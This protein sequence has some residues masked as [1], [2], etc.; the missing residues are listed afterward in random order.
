MTQDL[1]RIELSRV[2]NARDT[3]THVITLADAVK[4][5]TGSNN[6]ATV[7]EIRRL[8]VGGERE[9][10]DGIKRAL[11]AFMFAGTFTR[12]KND[13]IKQHSGLLV[14]DF[15]NIDTGLKSRLARDPHAVL[16]FVSPSGNGLKLVVRI[17]NDPTGHGESFEMARRYFSE[18]FSVEADAGKDLAR[19]CFVSHDPDAVFRDTAKVLHRPHMTIQTTHDYTDHISNVRQPPPGEHDTEGL[20]GLC[21]TNDV[22]NSTLPT[23]PGQRHR[24]L[25]SLARGLRFD[26]G[27]AEAPPKELKAIIR[28]WYEM[29]KPCIGTQ[30]F[31][32]SWSDFVHAWSRV[33]SPLSS[34]NPVAAAWAAVQGGEHPKEAEEYD[35]EEVRQLVALCWHLGRNAETFYLAMRTAAGMLNVEAMTVC[36]WFKMLQADDIIA[37]VKTGNTHT[38]STYRW[39]GRGTDAE[40]HA[41]NP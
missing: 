38:A 12:R 3:Q 39:Q 7:A 4:E 15:D 35:R 41:S 31:T 40:N 34:T 24:K 28:R 17:D 33:R 5:I 36:R 14:L 18:Q 19:L 16:C 6:A 32:E 10:A 13:A 29:A 26:C 11:P 27:L 37:L 8:K 22:L 20:Y 2:R 30:D 21:N 9:K 23:H 25:F 1:L